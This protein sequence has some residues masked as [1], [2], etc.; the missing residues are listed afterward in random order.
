M[1]MHSAVLIISTEIKSQG[2]EMGEIMGWGPESFTIPLSD[3]ELS[4]SHYALRADVDDQ[5]VRWITGIDPLPL[6]EAQ[7]VLASLIYDFSGTEHNL[8]GRDHLEWVCNQHNLTII[9]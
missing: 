7:T 1:V 2:N 5:F 8:W 4:I 3:N 6:S 9:G